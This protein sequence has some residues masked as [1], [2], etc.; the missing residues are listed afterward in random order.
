MQQYLDVGKI[1]NTHG[2][3]GEVKVFPLT[4]DPQR[5]KKLKWVYI[6]RQSS[7]DKLNIEGVKFFKNLVIIKF[8]GIDD[9][10][11]AETLKNLSLKVDREHAVK[12]P[13]DTYFIADIIGCEVFEEDTR[14]GIVEDVLQTGSNDVYVVKRE[15]KR[16]ILIP[17]LKSVVTEVS[18]PDR[19]IKVV[20]PEGL[21]EDEV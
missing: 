17:A 11:S 12:L 14:L 21:K 4:D 7:L 2:V 5:F 15:N 10:N 19:K 13:K 20:L 18:I 9:A 16:D 6:E 3:R 1:I 8:E